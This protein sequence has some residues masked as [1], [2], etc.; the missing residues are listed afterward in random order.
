[1][2]IAEL[3]ENGERTQDKSQF[4]NL[5]MVAKSD[6]EISSEETTLL[7]NLGKHLG[8]T[9]EAMSDIV[10]NP[11]DYE[12]KPP[13]SRVERFEQMVNLI[14][15]VQADGKVEDA[16]MSILE[17]IAVGIGYSDLDDVDVESILALIVRGEDTEVII[18]E[19]L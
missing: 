8:L 14:Q 6:G 1:M 9:E 10:K 3:F 19:L 18:Q 17:R 13:V 7:E 11:Q 5:V 16:E 2:S 15:M 12:I 4:R